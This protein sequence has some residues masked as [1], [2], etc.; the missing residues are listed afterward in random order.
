[1]R[2]S[3]GYK[4]SRYAFLAAPE[5]SFVRDHWMSSQALDLREYL[6]PLGYHLAALPVNVRVGKMMLYGTIFRCLDPV[7]TIAAGTFFVPVMITLRSGSF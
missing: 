2:Q 3:K 6:T 7:L 5:I 1:M 4:N